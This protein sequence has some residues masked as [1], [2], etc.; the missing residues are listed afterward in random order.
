MSPE[1]IIG[2]E[3]S[4]SSDVWSLGLIIYEMATG[5]FPYQ[6]GNDFLM[7]ITKIVEGPEPTL[8][9]NSYYSPELQ[10]FVV[11]CLKKD[12]NE[13]DSVIELCNHP[14]ILQSCSQEGDISEWLAELFDYNLLEQ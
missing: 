9:N 11:R 12:P 13:R 7:Q 10:N 8:P 2:K 5:I 6:D 1:R 4:Y 14:W 3:Y